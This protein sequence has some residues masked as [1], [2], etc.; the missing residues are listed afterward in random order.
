MVFDV[1]M[2]EKFRRKARFVVDV[3]K[4]KTLAA[5][6]YS[7]VVSRDSVRNALIIAVINDLDVLACD[8]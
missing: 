3:H 1:K 7:L 4:T 8:I 2:G 5:I 6:T